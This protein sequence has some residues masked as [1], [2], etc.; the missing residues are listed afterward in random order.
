LI[1]I[2]G[3]DKEIYR[4]LFG[5][6]AFNRVSENVR[7]LLIANKSLGR[8]VEI[9]VV[10]K[11]ISR[12]SVLR[13]KNYISLKRLAKRNNA[14]IMF[15]NVYDSWSGRISKEDMVGDMKLKHNKI[16]NEP[17]SLL[18]TTLTIMW[19][20]NVVPCCRDLDGDIILGN[21]MEQSIDEI[22]KSDAFERVRE[23]FTQG[24][25]PSICNKCGHYEGLKP[26]KSLHLLKQSFLLRRR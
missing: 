25:I 6:N 7:L 21:I 17:C 12:E 9:I 1:D 15:D 13:N 2:G 18:Y 20:G 11:I 19:N 8:K 5:T 16:K 4:V 14:R 22:W 26:L 3:M 10:I 23:S 24:D